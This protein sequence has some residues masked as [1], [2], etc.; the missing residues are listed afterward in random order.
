MK[1]VKIDILLDDLNFSKKILSG[2]NWDGREIVEKLYVLRVLVVSHFYHK[3]T[4]DT[5]KVKRE[6]EDC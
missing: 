2:F 6:Y 4:K 3:V 1:I 5:K